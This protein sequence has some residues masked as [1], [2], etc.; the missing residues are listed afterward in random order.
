VKRDPNSIPSGEMLRANTAVVLVLFAVLVLALVAVLA[1]LRAARNQSR[2]ERAEADAHQRLYNAYLA[3]ARATRI[4]GEEG[5]RASALGIVSNAAI[6]QVSAALRTEAIASLVLSDLI[7]EGTILPTPI[8]FVCQ[9]MDSS[10]EHYAYGDAEGLVHIGDFVKRRPLFELDARDL[11]KSAQTPAR[12]VTFS[13]D[14]KL[15]AARF[16]GAALV[17]WDLQSRKVLM[18]ADLNSTQYPLGNATFSPDSKNII[19]ADPEAQG[20][21]VVCEAATGRR[22]SV[23]V[24]AGI[25]FFRLRPDGQQA[26]IVEDGNVT[27]MDYPGGANARI[28][29]HSTRV[30]LLVWSP[31]GTHLATAGE[32]GD[33]YIWDFTN[34]SHRILR[35]HNERCVNLGFSRDGA[36]FFSSSRDGTTRLWTVAQGQTIATSEGT[37]ESF[38]PD[39]HRLGFWRMFSGFGIWSISHNIDYQLLPCPKS[40]G[41]LFTFDLSPSGRWCVATQNKGFRLWDL[42]DNDREYYVTTPEIYCARISPDDQSLYIGRGSGLEVWPLTNRINGEL[43]LDSTNAQPILLPGLLGARALALSLDG[44]S[45]CVELADHRLSILDLTGKRDPVFINGRYSHVNFKGPASATGAGRFSFSPDG[46]YVVTGFDFG[47]DDVPRVWDARSGE[48]LATLKAGSSVSVFSPDGRRLALAGMAHYS[49]WSA[50]DWRLLQDFDRDEPS[51]THGTIAIGRDDGIMAV[52]STRKNIQVLSHFGQEKLFDLISPTPQS[53]NSVR[54]SLD[55]SVL[56]TA[57]ANDMVQVWRLGHLQKELAALNLDWSSPSGLRTFAVVEPKTEVASYTRTTLALSLAGVLLAGVFATITLR[58]HRA[59]IARFISAEAK[60]MQR[61]RELEVA[62]GELM[63][64]QRMQALG[65]LAAGIAH[66]FN[67][68]L[69]VIRMSNKLIGRAAKD[70]EVQE[71]VADIE[72]AAVQ[73]KNVVRSM[74]G[75]ARNESFPSEHSNVNEVVA[76]TVSLLNKEFLGRIQ[77]ILEL[78]T[79]TL[80]VNINQGRLEQVLLNLI[81]NASEAMEGSGK[82]K[83]TAHTGSG[84]LNGFLVLCPQLAAR[85]VELRIGDSGPGISGEIM[86]RIF[87]PFF[88]TKQNASAPGTG[89]GLSLVYSIAQQDGLGLSVESVGVGTTF[90]VLIPVKNIEEKNSPLPVREKHSYRS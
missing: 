90:C 32:D 54:L 81:V 33:I 37:A 41:P 47:G 7:Q 46:R 19:F 69:S 60:T 84:N 83:I 15:L 51:I 50:V 73:G 5:R 30:S 82:L 4:S 86:G 28:L 78:A 8:D 44:Q 65:T 11:G 70:G 2:A 14:G 43:Q 62:K 6:I 3:A 48:L 26:A 18:S 23:G 24:K 20:K 25:N 10:L 80:R 39:G 53:I 45:A 49:L 12:N 52:A 22:L 17:V 42:Q 85:Y 59:S 75:Y 29:S 79:E 87:E 16:V 64:S 89:L 9:T 76:G 34:N 31:D 66:D 71:H 55:G 13:P 72:Q 35:G 21:I 63:H 67:N 56:A 74:L 38:S 58:Q 1:G 61:N 27:L 57:T 77:L 68:L 36:E 40:E 88:T